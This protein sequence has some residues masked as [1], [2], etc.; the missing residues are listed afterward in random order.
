[1]TVS[2]I[3]PTLN[4]AR[5]LGHVLPGIPDLVDELVIVDGGSTDGTLDVVRELRPDAVVVLEPQP[6]KG[7]ALQ[8]GFATATGDSGDHGADASMDRW[9]SSRSSSADAGADVAK[10]SRSAGGG[11]SDLPCPE[12]GKH[13]LTRCSDGLRRTVIDLCYGYMALWGT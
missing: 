12:D 7:M 5:N 13:A 11:S 6:G 3:I 2:L 8:A 4:E 9:T 1:M 10:G